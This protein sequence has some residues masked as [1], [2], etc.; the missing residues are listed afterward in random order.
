MKNF[1]GYALAIAFCFLS[2]NSSLAADA[3]S[4]TPN[5]DQIIAEAKALDVRP[6]SYWG[7]AVGYSSSRPYTRFD[8]Y[9][10]RLARIKDRY[11]R[12]KKDISAAQVASIRKLIG[13]TP[14]MK[15]VAAGPHKDVPVISNP[16]H[17]NL[18]EMA[19]QIAYGHDLTDQ[20]QGLVDFVVEH[21][22]K[23]T[24]IQLRGGWYDGLLEKITD[25]ADS[26]NKYSW[27]LSPETE[28][29]V[30]ELI[31]NSDAN[32]GFREGQVIDAL[33][34]F[35]P[36]DVS[37]VR[38]QI[39]LAGPNNGNTGNIVTSV[40]EAYLSQLD[41]AGAETREEYNQIELQ[42][43][44][45]RGQ[46]PR[47]DGGIDRE[48]LFSIVRRGDGV[49]DAEMEFLNALE[50]RARRGGDN[51]IN[52]GD[53]YTSILEGTFQGEFSADRLALATH[54]LENAND[55]NDMR[56]SIWLSFFLEGDASDRQL[57]VAKTIYD[58]ASTNNGLVEDDLLR[59]IG[60]MK[61]QPNR[62]EATHELFKLAM[63]LNK[64]GKEVI[65]PSYFD[66][67]GPYFK[68]KDLSDA[69]L[70]V[71]LEIIEAKRQN[72][73]LQISMY[74]LLN[75]IDR[76][77]RFSDQGP[78]EE[79]ILQRV[80]TILLTATSLGKDTS[81]GLEDWEIYR[82]TQR[83]TASLESIAAYVQLESR[84]QNHHCFKNNGASE[85]VVLGRLLKDEIEESFSAFP[86]IMDKVNK[87]L[88]EEFGGVSP[89]DIARK[90]ASRL[91]AGLDELLS[92][93]GT[94]ASTVGAE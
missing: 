70:A 58:N 61:D 85:R 28:K 17:L 38:A 55:K 2:G 20:E 43:K 47:M 4:E 15:M 40:R 86:D 62:L 71:V 67:I 51:D 23:I 66:A 49:S 65:K 30:R 87:C 74:E 94:G 6:G 82:L 84:K 32:N 60:R 90:Q 45:L 89:L 75:A 50:A 72:P 16:T 92:N 9:T 57:E 34:K 73:D 27:P 19:T 93:D 35:N 8:K 13:Y 83:S 54:V 26:P 11:T 59:N 5:L 12:D 56:D 81:P 48:K 53:E 3:A 29:L 91:P 22:P 24:D 44:I 69:Q 68:D 88:A 76:A 79:E 33:L 52:E 46:L 18:E 25:P 31:A 41:I 37:K 42:E 39:A 78:S 80:R 10:D 7:E 64:G 63:E 14:E 77:R 1:Y 21:A 36:R